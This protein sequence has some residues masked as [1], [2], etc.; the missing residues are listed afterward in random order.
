MSTRVATGWRL[1]SLPRISEDRGS[2]CVAEVYS[3]VP[4]AIARAFWVFDVPSG[5]RRACHAHRAQ[6][7]FIIAARGSFS[8]RVDDGTVRERYVLDA[9]DRGLFV[10]EL[11]WL[12][13]TD[14]SPDAICL[15]FASGP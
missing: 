14:F 8:A 4:F 6:Q 7:E 13:L 3:Q 2:L 10:P 5:Q 9:P 15:A 11:V 12:E 1:V